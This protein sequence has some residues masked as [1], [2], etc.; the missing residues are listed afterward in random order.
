MPPKTQRQTLMFSATFPSG[1][2]NL[3]A[4]FLNDHVFITVGK[5]GAANQDIVQELIQVDKFNKKDKLQELIMAD[6]E[7]AKD[8]SKLFCYLALKKVLTTVYISDGKYIK[9]TMVFVERKRT[10][11]FLAT[12]F[13]QA[14]VPTTSIHG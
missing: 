4:D 2:Q 14:A 10:A 3:A 13:S 1:V 9:K 6:M 8:E 12:F 11:D 7:N 5:V